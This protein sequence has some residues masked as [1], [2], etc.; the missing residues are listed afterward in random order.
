MNHLTLDDYLAV[1]RDRA[2]AEDLARQAE[3]HLREI[4]PGE[5]PRDAALPADLRLLSL[6]D[7][8]A[9]KRQLSRMREAGREA[10]KDLARLRKLP[11]EDWPHRVANARTRF[12]SRA[13]AQLLLAEG[14]RL[15]PRDPA[16]T[17]DLAALV[18]VALAWTGARPDL[19][20]AMETIA[21]ATALHDA[22]AVAQSSKRR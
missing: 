1:L 6:A 22:A 10:R 2:P 9:A 12:R 7:L 8:R 4:E 13:F 15:L 18:P 14:R 16:T 21:Q 19:G 20:W 11:R 5:P 3:A 17:A